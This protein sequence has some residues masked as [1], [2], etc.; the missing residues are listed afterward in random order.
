[1]GLLEGR[2]GEMV[3]AQCAG[4]GDG[5]DGMGAGRVRGYGFR[6]KGEGRRG[7]GLMV[8]LLHLRLGRTTGRWFRRFVRCFDPSLKALIERTLILTCKCHSC[9]RSDAMFRFSR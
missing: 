3:Q 6:E 9:S 2:V 7:Y 1:M 4:A 8:R 5:R